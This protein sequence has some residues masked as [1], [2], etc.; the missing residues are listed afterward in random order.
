[1]STRFS[2]GVDVVALQYPGRQDRRHEPCIAT[3][4]ELADLVAEELRSLSE[5]PT[6]FFGHSMGA[7]LAFEVARRL[8]HTGPGAP[9][10]IVASGRRG[11]ATQRDEKV[12]L[13]S[14]DD[15]IAVPS[16]P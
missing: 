2:P 14:D 7:T 9:G 12:H 1:M 4:G 8:E 13:G 6:I 15:V 10:A 16:P 11:P 5:K 3:I